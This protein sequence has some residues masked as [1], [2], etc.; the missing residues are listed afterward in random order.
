MLTQEENSRLTQVAAGTPM[1]ELLRRYWYPVA[2][3]PELDR[4]PV[5][6]VKILGEELV[7]FRTEEGELGLVDRRCPHRGAALE[8]GIPEAK[9]LRCSYHGWKYDTRGQCIE[10]PVETSARDFA[11]RVKIKSYPV[12]ELG[13]L[14]WTYM[15][16][17]PAPLLPRYDLLA[18]EDMDREIGITRA[19]P[20]NWFQMMENSM[21]P[22][23]V[24]F[25]HAHYLN[26]VMKRRGKPPA[27]VP[28]RHVKIAFDK[29]EHGLVKRRLLEGQSEDA[30]DWTI[31]HPILFPNILA[32]GSSADP[33]FQIRVPIDE[34]H[35]QYYWYHARPRK[36]GT[37]PQK[38]IPIWDNPY[39]HA[40][41][42]LVVETVNGQDMMI[43]LVQGEIADRTREMLASTDQG[44]VLLRQT[45]MAQMEKVARGEDPLGTV[46]DPAKNVQIVLP[47]ESHGHY[48]VD[49]GFLTQ[50]D[51]EIIAI[52][53]LT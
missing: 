51:P 2:A 52:K 40:D 12:Q 26:Y 4:E 28:R 35:T 43:W 19:L 25:L 45:M 13:G 23:H 38:S 21:D 10:Q 33:E 3:A 39:Q 7:L 17:A 6:A 15:G 24:E 41:G 8:Y 14:V 34:T 44:V 46:R 5:L 18:R 50:D 16:P 37:P 49:G 53:E 31:G 29:F 1:G 47:R 20:C 9:G 32:V 11:H 48:T 36:P 30:D 42:R 22:V 27:S